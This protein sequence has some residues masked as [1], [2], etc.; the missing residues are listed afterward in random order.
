LNVRVVTLRG[1]VEREKRR[2]DD[3]ERPYI[4]M[5]LERER[6]VERCI[7]YLT[8]VDELCPVEP[9]VEVIY[10]ARRETNIM[11]NDPDGEKA[12]KKETIRQA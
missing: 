7:V 9:L 8:V 1:Q 4:R 5:E 12:Q 11:A 2:P 3:Q 6:I 10:M